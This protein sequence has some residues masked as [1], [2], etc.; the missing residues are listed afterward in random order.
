MRGQVAVELF[1]AMSIGLLVLFWFVNYS[2]AF[3]DST[4]TTAVNEQQK[5]FAKSLANTVN[6]VCLRNVNVSV[7][8]PCL[9]AQDQN[10]LYEI[11]VSGDRLRVYNTFS[12]FNSSEP[13]ACQLVDELPRTVQCADLAYACMYKHPTDPLRVRLKEGFC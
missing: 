9:F 8:I 5:W 1:L 13:T 11:D 7:K 3:S 10:V 4:R 12:N 2:T 6:E